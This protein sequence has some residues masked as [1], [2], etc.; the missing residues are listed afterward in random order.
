MLD[1]SAHKIPTLLEFEGL[2]DL[3]KADS[4][5]TTPKLKKTFGAPCA[6]DDSLFRTASVSGIALRHFPFPKCEGPFDSAQGGHLDQG[7]CIN[8]HLGWHWTRGILCGKVL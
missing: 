2:E 4:S 8:A 5:L 6:Q 1:R 3:K 7:H